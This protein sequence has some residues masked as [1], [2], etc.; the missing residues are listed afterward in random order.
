M[1]PANNHVTVTSPNEINADILII[2]D[3]P[4]NLRLLYQMLSQYYK[5]R[6]APSG[7][8]GLAAAHSILPDLIL[9]DI[10]MPGMNGYEVAGQLKSDKLTEEIPIIFMSALDDTE[11]KVR[12]FKVGGIDYVTKPFQEMEVLARV[13]TH[14]LNR[15]LYKQAQ[16]EIAERKRV[17]AELRA[18]QARI[19]ALLS[20][21][22]DTMY[23]IHRNGTIIDFK[24]ADEELLFAPPDQII[25]ASLKLLLD[26]NLTRKFLICIEEVLDHKKMLTMEYSIKKG[27]S[28]RIFE[29]RFKDSDQ[30]EVIAIIRDISVWARLEQMKSDFINRASHELRTP[31]AT[32]LIM[33]SLIDKNPTP[34]EFNEYW[35][36]IKSEIKN[37]QLLVENLLDVGRMENDQIFLNI[38]RVNILAVLKKVIDQFEIQARDKKISIRREFKQELNEEIIIPADE[39][40]LVA[41]NTGFFRSFYLV[42]TNQ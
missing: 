23:R 15:T 11:S 5:V 19:S 6:L 38:C 28:S 22:P 26:E 7:T 39:N 36:I 17:E 29:A 37:E 16:A 32:M 34:E 4:E 1:M 27:D 24:T 30:D 35:A 18:S 42:K 12:G 25:G 41:I 40:N 13:K 9:L 21:V 3:T 20:A 14:I 31:I 2:D 33:A 10:M 8:T